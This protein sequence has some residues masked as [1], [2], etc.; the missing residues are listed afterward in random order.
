LTKAGELID[1]QLYL[2]FSFSIN[3]IVVKSGLQLQSIQKYVRREKAGSVGMRKK[4]ALFGHWHL[5]G[6]QRQGNENHA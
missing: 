2:F 4:M 3:Q 1:G 5:E 6:G